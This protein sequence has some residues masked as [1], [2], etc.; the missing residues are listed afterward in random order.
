[1]KIV[2]TTYEDND[3]QVFRKYCVKPETTEELHEAAQ[4]VVSFISECF[5]E[6]KEEGF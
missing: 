6:L 2:L 4:D 5:D 3:E 1:M